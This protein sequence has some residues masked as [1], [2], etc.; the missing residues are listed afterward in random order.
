MANRK[1]TLILKRSSVPGKVPTAGDLLLGEIAINTADVI[2][3]ASGTTSNSILPIG[4]D[5]VARTG[6]T[7]TGTLYVPTISATTYLGLSSSTTTIN[8]NQVAFGSG[9][10]GTIS[11]NSNFSYDGLNV[12][13]GSTAPVSGSK[14]YI[15]S[16][17]NVPL[18]IKNS[19]FGNSFEIKDF[20]DSTQISIDNTYQLTFNAGINGPIYFGSFSNPSGGRAGFSVPGEVIMGVSANNKRFGFGGSGVWFVLNDPSALVHIKGRADEVQQIIEGYSTQ[21][22]N[23]S[24]WRDSSNNN[25]LYVKPSG[26]AEYTNDLSSNYTNRSLVDKE[27]VD[28]K[29]FTGG[30]V[31]GATNFT[32]GLT[33]NTISAT[34]YLGLPIDLTVT[35]GTY[36]NGTA[37]FTNNTGGTFNVTGFVSADTFTTG[38]TYSNNVLTLQQNQGQPDLSILID[39]MTGLTVSG[40]VTFSGGSILN[41]DYLQFNV[42]YT[43]NTTVE[44]RM[45]WDEP[46]GTVSLG[47]HGSQVSQQ[48]GLEY[49][50]YIKNQSGATIE[51]GRVVRAA[52]TL[53][54]SGRILGEY[55]IADGSIPAKYSL[56]IATENIIDGEDG[57]VT[58]FGLVS[59]IN[60]TGS[61]YGETWVDGDILYVSPT[62]SGGLTNVEPIAPQLKIEM[63][64][65]I[66]AN[67]NGS[68]FVRP[69]RYPYLNDLQNLSVTGASDGDLL[70]F[71]NS[72]NNVWVNTKTLNGNYTISGSVSATTYQNLPSPY[73][74][75][76]LTSGS[77]YTFTDFKVVNTLSINKITGSTTTVTLNQTPN[78]NDFYVVKDR[79]GD[80]FINQ[81]VITGGTYTIDGNA[82]VIMKSKNNPSLTFLFDGSEY[83]II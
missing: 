50:Y 60:T 24:E 53:G 10:S 41:P 54:A 80:S 52:G 32:G 75:S 4:W 18:T 7:M 68:I 36:D 67:I 22:A 40:D 74:T 17:S 69:N 6:D 70:V 27:Y 11:S 9:S 23:L 42:D 43:G 66:R 19:S 45:Y 8:E 64:I 61:L 72:S 76:I 58:E 39:A 14:L 56:G 33:A 46:N 26:L 62:I 20:F 55:M 79:K 29:S 81:I 83:I 21:N 63:A 30:T 35:G 71:S 34:T 59:N 44:G 82:S 51:N 15:E 73:K 13:I 3:Y 57:Y 77:S 28:K 25:L 78:V 49:Y 31:T 65:V 37:I 12:S 5:R 48:I 16:D 1:N 2:L 47:M 38:F